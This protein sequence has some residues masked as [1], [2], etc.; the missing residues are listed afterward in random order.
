M[1]RPAS[2]CARKRS[3]TC[4]TPVYPHRSPPCLKSSGGL[5]CSF[6]VH[7]HVCSSTLLEVTIPPPA[8][9]ARH[10]PLRAASQLGVARHSSL[11]R[12][13]GNGRALSSTSG[14]VG[15]DNRKRVDEDARTAAGGGASL[16]ELKGVTHREGEGEDDQ[17]EKASPTYCLVVP[18]AVEGRTRDWLLSWVARRELESALVMT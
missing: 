6:R 11:L 8:D 2:R 16:P 1:L 3:L 14:H 18:I 10:T 15:G 17:L 13:S 12:L 4:T 7:Q 9:V 5:G